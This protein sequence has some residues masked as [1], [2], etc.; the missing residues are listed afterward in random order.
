MKELG[1]EV[2][3]VIQEA[4]SHFDK[5]KALEP[6]NP[7]EE[8]VSF[9]SLIDQLS[10]TNAK[11]YFQKDE[12]MRRQD[13]KEFLAWQAVQDIR[14]VKERARLKKCIDDKI[15]AMLRRVVTGDDSAGN[16]PEVK[17]YGDSTA[18]V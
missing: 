10:I 3:L 2:E 4:L 9:S 13:D 17:K 11:L 12:V 8:Q 5:V 6:H 1:N 16:N 7:F 18:A 14:L 15:I